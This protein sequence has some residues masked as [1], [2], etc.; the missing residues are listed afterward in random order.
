MM[1]QAFGCIFL[2]SCVSAIEVT[3][4]YP[5]WKL[6]SNEQLRVLDLAQNN[7]MVLNKVNTSTWTVTITEEALIR[8]VKGKNSSFDQSCGLYSGGCLALGPPTQV[9]SSN[10]TLYPYFLFGLPTRKLFVV[11][12]RSFDSRISARNVSMSIPYSFSENPFLRSFALV[13]LV[14]IDFDTFDALSSIL[15]SATQAGKLTDFV[16]VY[17]PADVYELTYEVCSDQQSCG[18]FGNTSF[19]GATSFEQFLRDSISILSSQSGMS[20]S[21]IYLAGWGLGGLFSCYSPLST[22]LFHGVLCVSPTLWWNHNSFPN[23]ILQSSSVMTKRIVLTFGTQEGLPGTTP[24]LTSIGELT[25]AAFSTK[26][27]T[28]G[29]NLSVF[30]VP[31]GT[32]SLSSWSQSVVGDFIELLGVPQLSIDSWAPAIPTTVPPVAPTAVFPSCPTTAPATTAPPAA[33]DM[34]GLYTSAI[35]VDV[36]VTIVIFD[37]AL[38]LLAWYKPWVKRE[39]AKIEARTE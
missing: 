4:I 15:S 17:V 23:V 26:G 13:F 27:F 28:I 22:L 34:S 19:G 38:F 25:A 37:M 8:I 32:A 29:A 18:Y 3:V 33:C 31:G 39:T 9:L 30:I 7:F 10:I 16:L 21:D 11:E 6:D 20:F 1:G 5:E 24:S 36:V 2:I 12:T 14:G 35:M